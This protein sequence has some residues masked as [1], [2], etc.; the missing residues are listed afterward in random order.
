MDQAFK[1]LSEIK[2]KNITPDLKCGSK[3]KTL[4]IKVKA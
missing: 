4:N 1:K 3:D 2:V